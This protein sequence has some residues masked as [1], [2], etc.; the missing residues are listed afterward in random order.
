MTTMLAPSEP[1]VF[2]TNFDAAIEFYTETLGFEVVF[3]YGEPAFYG[4]IRRD[5]ALVNLRH[6]DAS[7]FREEVRE[8]DELLSVSFNVGNAADVRALF[9][10]FQKA[11]ADFYRPLK[12]EKWGAR[13]FILRDPF[14]NLLM[15]TGTA[16]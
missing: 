7:P 14:G 15:F 10:E 12:Q 1:F 4:Q 11:G 6:V 2:V 8:S 3:T 5:K 16:E 13:T 9:E